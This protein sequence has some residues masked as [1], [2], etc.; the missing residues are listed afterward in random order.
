MSQQLKLPLKEDMEII[1]LPNEFNQ[2]RDSN[3]SDSSEINEISFSS[4]FDLFKYSKTIC[5]N[6]IIQNLAS[7]CTNQL[8]LLKRSHNIKNENINIFFRLLKNE[9]IEISNE[10]FCELYI[11]SEFFQVDQLIHILKEYFKR[12]IKDVDLVIDFLINQ[13]STQN[14]DDITSFEFYKEIEESLSSKIEVCF[15]NPNFGKL[16]SSII[17]RI[18][19]RSDKNQISSDILY[20]FICKNINEKFILLHF[21]NIRNLSED[22]LNSLYELLDNY[23]NTEMNFII[24]YLPVDLEYIKELR[25]D[26]I[27]I[28]EQNH[29]LQIQLNDKTANIEQL[30]PQNDNLQSQLDDIM[31]KLEQLQ[32]QNNDLQN[33]LR[34][35]EQE[36]DS[37]KTNEKAFSDRIHSILPQEDD[38]DI[39]S[40]VQRDVNLSDNIRNILKDC[41]SD[42]NIICCVDKDT[43]LSCAIRGFFQ[44]GDDPWI[45]NQII[46][47]HN[48]IPQLNNHL[49]KLEKEKNDQ[50]MISDELKTNH[51]NLQSEHNNLKEDYQNLQL[52]VRQIEQERDEQITLKNE[53]ENK[54]QSQREE[55][56]AYMNEAM[57]QERKEALDFFISQISEIDE[58]IASG[59]TVLHIGCELGKVKLVKYLLSNTYIDINLKDIH[60]FILFN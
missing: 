22:R 39:A 7:N 16:P 8:E 55:L 56:L 11:L 2:G 41:P 17:Y 40:I 52:Q 28:I 54:L 15:I 24:N 12:H 4:L 33:R 32:S 14:N 59:K 38:N 60:I 50:M 20:D 34:E 29:Q 9:K 49:N 37:L 58:I 21:L 3:E 36:R 51:Q 27:R 35:V 53:L 6:D 43:K 13:I 26:N 23:K 1:S 47:D 42:D 5:K 57:F 46:D 25:D 45:K 18:I 31:K 19:E 30:Q 10:Q 48:L 44:S